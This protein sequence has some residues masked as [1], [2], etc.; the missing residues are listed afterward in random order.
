MIAPDNW[1]T[2]RQMILADSIEAESDLG[3][4]GM[5]S[6]ARLTAKAMAYLWRDHLEFGEFEDLEDI[7]KANGV[8]RRI[9]G[10]MHQLTSLARAFRRLVILTRDTTLR[11]SGLLRSVCSAP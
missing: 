9:D 7:A 8:D 5:P 6:N 10:R 1:C 4:S 2:G 11:R 3:E